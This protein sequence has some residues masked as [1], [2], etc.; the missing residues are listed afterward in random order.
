MVVISHDNF[1]TAELLERI[2]CWLDNNP[3]FKVLNM[4]YRPDAVGETMFIYGYTGPDRW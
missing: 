2:Q 4:A 1:D 3:R